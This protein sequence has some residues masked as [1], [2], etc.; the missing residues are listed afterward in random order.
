MTTPGE[1]VQGP[2]DP[3]EEVSLLAEPE[4]GYHFVS[5]TGD[6]DT[7][8]EPTAEST[9]II[10]NG[11]YEITAYFAP[12]GVTYTLFVSSSDG[13]SVTTPGEGTFPGYDAGTVVNLLAVPLTGYQFVNWTGDVAGVNDAATTITMNDDEVVHAN[14]AEV[15]GDLGDLIDAIL[16][17]GEDTL[18]LPAGTYTGDVIIDQPITITGTEG[19]TFIHGGIHVA[20]LVGSNVTIEN[21]IITD[22]TAYGIW[23]EL[24]GADDVFTIRNNTIRGAEGSVTGI[25]VDAV[26][27][28]GILE[29]EQNSI[30]GNEVGVKLLAAVADGGI[31]FN[32]I[33]GNTIGLEQL[34]VGSNAHADWNWWGD[35]SGPGEENQNP[36]GIGDNVTGNIGTQPW[37]TRD[38]QTVLDDNIAYFGYAW[39]WLY[40][41][42]NIISTPVALDPLVEWVDSD[43]ISRTGVDTWGDYVALGD[44]LS[45]DNTSPVYS[46]D[47]E[48][49]AWVG[50]TSDD[51]LDPCEAIYVRMAEPDIA[52]ILYSPDVSVPSEEMYAGW[53]LVS[54][55]W[56]PSGISGDGMPA[57]EALVT[58]EEVSGGLTGYKLVVS[59]G[60]ND[61]EGSWIHIAGQTIEP[62]TDPNQPPPDGYMFIASG[63]WVFMLNDGTLA[64]FAFTPVSL[65]MPLD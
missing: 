48:N 61:Y 25:K 44:G 59:P 56:L 13:G 1:G 47:A 24:V 32:D 54:L 37:L 26:E 11:D 22:Y 33:T 62:W 18:E 60:V 50:L 19:E 42:W 40:T 17:A 7:V 28:G 45:T 51:T 31:E 6:V 2:Y 43:N 4:E 14:F 46:F 52:P 21:L 41:G 9:T 10:M 30:S 29:V 57:D 55:A 20:P 16:V 12:E 65:P 5:W 35:I 3:E 53:N 34:A 64:G 8:A 38:F 36:G 49:Q 58:V 15:T 27:A 63:Y 23:I 39:V